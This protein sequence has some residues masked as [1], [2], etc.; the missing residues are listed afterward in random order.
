MAKGKMEISF[1]EGKPI[2]CIVC[3]AELYRKS[4]YYCS[5]NCESNYLD[6]QSDKEKPP[7]LSKWKVKKRLKK[8]RN[9]SPNSK[10]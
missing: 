2:P 8:Q 9:K 4:E 7:F 1:R 3:G 6:K 10:S 5:K